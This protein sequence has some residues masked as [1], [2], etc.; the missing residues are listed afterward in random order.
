MGRKLLVIVFSSNFSFWNDF[1][2]FE[3][4]RKIMNSKETVVNKLKW[5]SFIEQLHFITAFFTLSFSHKFGNYSWRYYDYDFDI[6]R[7]FK[8]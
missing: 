4:V 5:N 8:L 3:T 1:C 2:G 7:F 6:K